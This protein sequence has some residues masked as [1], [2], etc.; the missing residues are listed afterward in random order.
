MLELRREVGERSLVLLLG[1]D[2]FAGLPSWNHWQALFDVA[3]IGVLN[4]PGLDTSMPL[5][6]AQFV[7]LRRAQD[8]D[9]IR[10][11]SAG[12]VIELC[13]TPLE[14][15]ATRI[16]ELLAEGRDPR[17]LLPAGLFDD[18]ALLAPYRSGQ[19]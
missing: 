7:A 19:V 9:V 3:H 15:S 11:T 8:A 18:A 1:A 6:L 5:E 12:R 17:Y 16:R 14:I 2:A 13:V 10:N 4:R